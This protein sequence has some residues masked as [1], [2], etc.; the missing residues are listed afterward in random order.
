MMIGYNASWSL[1]QKYYSVRDEREA[2]RAAWCAAALNFAGAPLMIAPALIARQLI[3][4]LVEQ[5]RT[6]DVYVL[7]VLNCCPWV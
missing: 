7:L 5:G 2:A 1:A 3:P 4:G 6:A